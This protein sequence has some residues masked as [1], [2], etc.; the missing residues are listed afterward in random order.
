MVSPCARQNLVDA[1]PQVAPERRRGWQ[2]EAPDVEIHGDRLGHGAA[3]RARGDQQVAMEEAGGRSRWDVDLDQEA[4]GRVSC[5]R[6]R[7]AAPRLD[8][9]HLLPHAARRAEPRLGIRPVRHE[10]V[11]PRAGSPLDP[12]GLGEGDGLLLVDADLASGDLRRSSGERERRELDR[13][14]LVA[15]EQHDVEELELVLRAPERH[16]RAQG[17]GIARPGLERRVQ[18]ARQR[19]GGTRAARSEGRGAKQQDQ[20]AEKSHLAP[21]VR[22]TAPVDR[23]GCSSENNRPAGR[24]GSVPVDRVASRQGRASVVAQGE[25]TSPGLR[26]TST[27]RT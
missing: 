6:D 18:G 10:R 11:G 9:L 27:G 21:F 26:F 12:G 3:S 4:P 17:P 16:A 7:E 8:G 15:A 5:D 20:H 1:E 14:A 22:E 24:A 2:G 23:R 19:G 13:H 25:G